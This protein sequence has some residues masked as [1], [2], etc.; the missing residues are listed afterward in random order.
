MAVSVGTFP[1]LG[2]GRDLDPE[3]YPSGLC[4]DCEARF[5]GPEGL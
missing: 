1:C 3:E 5:G 2:C 4:P